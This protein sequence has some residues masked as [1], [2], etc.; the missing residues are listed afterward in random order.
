MAKTKKRSAKPG[1]PLPDTDLDKVA[2]GIDSPRP[3]ANL[4]A[5]DLQVAAGKAAGPQPHLAF[6]YDIKG[7]KEG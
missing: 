3:L 2:G 7:N 5:E 6:K 1:R 4:D